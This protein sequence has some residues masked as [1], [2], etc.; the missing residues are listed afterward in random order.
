L[1]PDSYSI[2]NN[3]DRA[4]MDVNASF[5]SKENE[6]THPY[7]PPPNELENHI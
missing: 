5:G 4:I 7:L 3:E 2:Q 6:N 1:D